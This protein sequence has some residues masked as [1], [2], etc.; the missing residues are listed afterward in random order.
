MATIGQVVYNLQDFHSSG[1]LISTSIED[2]SSTITSE[3]SNYAE[4]RVNI[5]T[6]D[7]VKLFKATSFSKLGIQAP[8]G[9]KVRL[10]LNKL[11]M[12]GRTGVYELD[13]DIE[14]TGLQFERPKKYIVDT[15]ATQDSLWQG[16]DGF[17]TAERDRKIALSDL[18]NKYKNK[19]KDSDYWKRYTEIQDAYAERY[20]EAQ[21]KYVA[22]VNGIYILPNPDKEDADENYEEL[23]NVIVDFVY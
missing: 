23:Y 15:I 21:A 8:P 20:A 3:L 13:E 6:N 19:D 14:I 9:T 18:D 22:G 12:I 7:L 2:L 11:I 5:F 16:I 1:G 4:A 10:N 17:E